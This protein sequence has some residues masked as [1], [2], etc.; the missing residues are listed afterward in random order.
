[1]GHYNDLLK[2][3][4]KDPYFKAYGAYLEMCEHISEFYHPKFPIH[5]KL[6]FWIIE[7]LFNLAFKIERRHH[8]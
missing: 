2:E 1:M 3:F 8:K 4:D 5:L 7:Y 6:I